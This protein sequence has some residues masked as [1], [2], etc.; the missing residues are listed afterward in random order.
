MTMIL[1]GDQRWRGK[2]CKTELF[3][4]SQYNYED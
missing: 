2:K 4:T 3:E 1:K